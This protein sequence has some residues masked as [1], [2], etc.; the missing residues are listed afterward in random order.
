MQF[1]PV[2]FGLMCNYTF[3][4]NSQDLNITMARTKA[5]ECAKLEKQ[6]DGNVS[7]SNKGIKAKKPKWLQ[8]KTAKCGKKQKQTKEEEEGTYNRCFNKGKKLNL[9]PVEKMKEALKQ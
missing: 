2:K 5:S 1:S 3:M 8:K 7:T 6:T 4:S 9:W